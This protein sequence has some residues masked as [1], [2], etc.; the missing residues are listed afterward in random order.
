[1]ENSESRKKNPESVIPYPSRRTVSL[2]FIKRK[3]TRAPD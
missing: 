3:E 1:M 2:E